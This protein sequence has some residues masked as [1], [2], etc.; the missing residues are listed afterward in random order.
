LRKSQKEKFL[1]Q[2][3]ETLSCSVRTQNCFRARK[4]RFIGDLVQ[5]TEIDLL[6]TNNFGRICLEEVKEEL[7]L[8]G[9]KLGMPFSD[10]LIKKF[11]KLRKPGKIRCFCCLGEVIK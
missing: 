4:I 7:H 3:V 11:N 10:P 1:S 5:R 8:R 2:S 9:L 6:R